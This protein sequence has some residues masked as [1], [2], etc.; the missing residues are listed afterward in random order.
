[1][2]QNI[3]IRPDQEEIYAAE[4]GWGGF[5]V[6]R[7]PDEG[8]FIPFQPYDHVR[9]YHSEAKA[10]Q[11]NPHSKIWKVTMNWEEVESE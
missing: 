5:T 2:S 1:M 10:R 11:Y 8:K 4:Q 6:R 9:I 3:Y 7:G